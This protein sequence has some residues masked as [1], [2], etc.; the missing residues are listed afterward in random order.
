MAHQRSAAGGD[1]GFTLIEMIVAMS[2]M[3]VLIAVFMGGVIQMTK[4]TS[5]VQNVSNS[6]DQARR[7]YDRFERTARVASEV[8]RPVLVG[9]TWY[10]EFRTTATGTSTPLCTQWRMAGGT[11]LLQRRT[12]D[13]VASPTVSDWETVATGVTD[14][15][16]TQQPFT[17]SPADSTYGRQRVAFF[18]A[19]TNGSA[20]SAQVSGLVVARN[21]D[22]TTTTNPDVDGDGI[23]D[24]QVCQQ[25]G[26]P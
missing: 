20:G 21:T 8:N 10:L 24:T 9:T 1:G 14:G 3:A 7:A 6:A 5:R 2:L 4:D 23:S 11:H 17:M 26:R 15:A 22:T 12:W 25:A 19:V 18:L 13:D 16:S